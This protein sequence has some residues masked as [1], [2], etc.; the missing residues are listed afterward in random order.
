[1]TNKYNPD[2]FQKK[3]IWATNADGMADANSKRRGQV[4]GSFNIVP[5]LSI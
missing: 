1:M 2:I 5:F 3:P 4:T